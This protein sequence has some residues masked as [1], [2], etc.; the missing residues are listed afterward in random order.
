[1]TVPETTP[2]GI[3]ELEHTIG[4]DIPNATSDTP[5]LAGKAEEGPVHYLAYGS[6]LSYKTFT[7]RRGITPIAATN[8]TVPNLYLTY[9]LAGLP[10]L[11]PSVANITY[12]QPSPDT[13]QLHG[14]VYTI[15]P[16]DFARIIATEGGGA[17]YSVIEVQC[18]PYDSTKAEMTAKTL[19]VMPGN[20]AIRE[21]APQPSKRYLGLLQTG[22]AENELDEKYRQW[23][24]ETVYYIAV[25]WRQ[26]MG[27]LVF[28]GC[29]LPVF[30][31]VMAGN[32]VLADKEGRVPGWWVAVM[33]R[34]FKAVWG[35]YDTVA[36]KVFG[37]GERRTV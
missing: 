27:K 33:G 35:A 31:V 13:P 18:K 19:Y 36:K 5:L 23:L 12:T 25:T 11:E 8:V 3:T 6:N 32:V 37:D 22:A 21:P 30:V 24:E 1:M 29:M 17:S 34:L 7:T 16:K 20:S 10:Y 2:A 14:V 4:A 26:K 28:A 15:T 9:N